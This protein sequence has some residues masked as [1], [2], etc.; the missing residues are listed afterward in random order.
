MKAMLPPSAEIV[1][2]EGYDGIAVDTQGIL[3]AIDEK[4]QLVYVDHVLFRSAYIVN[5]E[6]IIEKAHS[7]GAKVM[8]QWL[9]CHGHYSRRCD[10]A[11]C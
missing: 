4:T 6:A 5:V 7:V 1:M 8:V 2:A 11:K 9:P 3:D 10:R